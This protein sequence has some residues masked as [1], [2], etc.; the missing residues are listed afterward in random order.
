MKSGVY[1]ITNV[2]NN[3]IYVGSTSNLKNR[4][5]GHFS[6]LRKGIHHNK[7]LQFSYNK[8]GESNFVFEVLEY[9]DISLIT[10]REQYYI[11]T[12][13]PQYNKRIDAQNNR[14]MKYGTRS[15]EHK[16]KLSLANVGKVLSL[17]IRKAI[18]K[19]LKG[20]PKPPRS[21]EHSE[22]IAKTKRGVPMNENLKEKL[23]L[24]NTGRKMK[25]ESKELFRLK[26]CVT[27]YQY[28][29]D[30]VFIKEWLGAAVAARAL[31]ITQ[32]N[33]TMCCQGKRKQAMG[34]IWSYIKLDEV[35]NDYGICKETGLELKYPEKSKQ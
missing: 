8:Y 12:L 15:E 6:S 13:K 5:T 16:K 10:K 3:K 7:H 20:K 18:S 27:V 19:S 24:A 21:K 17:E 30:K 2:V 11:D 4:R 14:G 28:S 31:G 1:K 25:E 34:F 22:K 23:R 29:L 33:I 9:C 32:S 35:K 26:M